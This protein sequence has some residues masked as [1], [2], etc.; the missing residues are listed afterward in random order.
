M[1]KRT[2]EPEKVV[3]AEG[4]RPKLAPL[5][6]LRVLG[7]APAALLLLACFYTLYF[8]RGFFL[9]IVLA[10]LASFLLR[11]PVRFLAR[12]GVPDAFGAALVLA[13]VLAAASLGVYRVS[14]PASEWI[15]DAPQTLR[16][17]ERTFRQL[18]KPVEE[19]R[20]ATK[21]VEDLASMGDGEPAVP[22]VE[23]ERQGLSDVIVANTMAVGAGGFTVVV[24]LY[25]LLAAGDMF[26]RK[27]VRVLPRLEERKRAV[28]IARRIQHDVSTYLFTV[29]A[30]NTGLGVCVGFAMYMLE[31]P[32][33][34]LW[35]VMAGVFN[36]VPYVGP[37]VGA[38]VLL[39]VGL[40]TYEGLGQALG[41]VGAFVTLTALEGYLITP[42]ILGRRLLLNPVVL[43][44]GVIFWGWLWGVPGAVL[45]VPIM[46]SVKILCDNIE[47]LTPLAEFLG[48]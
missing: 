21:Q 15:A 27:L 9:P 8:A 17:A 38:G 32:N 22:E 5:S 12:R 26:L 34:A 42:L 16:Q 14:G 30:I 31:M 43:F 35:G 44:V 23:V 2:E 46:A 28:E 29:S 39:L 3:L 25:F 11:P 13:A 10:V 1:S 20:K 7:T 45:A 33:P 6:E 47:R 41:V 37:M 18:R 36:F 24:L 19:V 40:A 4:V 48:P